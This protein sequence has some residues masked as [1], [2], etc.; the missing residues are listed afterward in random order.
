MARTAISVPC[1]GREIF[2]STLDRYELVVFP[3]DVRGA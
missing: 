1:W 2:G 3:N